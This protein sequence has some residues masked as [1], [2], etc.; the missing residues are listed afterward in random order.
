VPERFDWHPEPE[1]IDIRDPGRARAA[2]EQLGERMWREA[3]DW[4]YGVAMQRPTA[5]ELYPELRATYYG[6]ADGPGPAPARGRVSTEVLA[7]FRERL[8]P[9][10]FSVQ[11]PGSFSY[12]TPPPLPMAVVGETLAAWTNQGID[13]WLAGMAAP[14]VE[15]EVI[16]WL[17]DVAGYD[18]GSWG[19]LT[20]GGVMANVMGLTVARDIHLAKLLGLDAPP[21][22]GQLEGVRVYASD[23]AHFSIARGLDMLG[24]PPQTLHIIPTDDRFRLH[25][26]AVAE[27]IAED[28]AAGLTPLCITPVAGS[29]NTGSVD[30]I[31][32]LADLGEREGLWLHV[33]AA[34]GGA[35]R[36]SPRDAGHVRDLELAD[37]ITIDP[38]KWFFQPY[39]IG[40]LLVKRREDLLRTFHWEPEYYRVWE[41]EDR[42]LNWYQYSLEGTRRF[43]ALKLWLSW[44]HLGTEGFA[45][46]VEHNNDLAAHLASRLRE[47]GGFEIIDP[48]L[49]V[50]CFRHLPAALA[51]AAGNA[52]DTYQKGL[53]RALEVSGAGWVSTTTLRGRTYLR[54]GIVNYLST[55]EDAD[56]VV[57]TLLAASE[58][59]LEQLDV[60]TA[61]T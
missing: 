31:G 8:A 42:P 60:G 45:R 19:V 52:V 55:E 47:S 46:L 58:R 12:F 49:S 4:L 14:F 13:L 38:H 57:D 27:A 18:D 36:L 56:R 9:Y 29:T 32:E 39:D 34:Y 37:S 17:C 20:S 35:A 61:G 11:H 21:R 51:S 22:A 24:F 28:R 54:A 25:A 1:L 6:D 48:E 26:E 50:V 15:E 2:L 53:Q 44:K 10:L 33:D 40:T 5:S 30:L 3:L 7:E 16:H 59:V 43:R 41:P 23:Q